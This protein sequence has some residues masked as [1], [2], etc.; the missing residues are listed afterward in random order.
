MIRLASY[1]RAKAT[2]TWAILRDLIITCHKLIPLLPS[3]P[4]EHLATF[5]REKTSR[6]CDVKNCSSYAITIGN[7]VSSQKYPG[8]RS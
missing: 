1:F 3:I 2:I 8:F 6:Y 7:F 4:F 5:D